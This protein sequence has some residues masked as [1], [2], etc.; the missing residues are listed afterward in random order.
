MIA[1]D[2]RF[3]YEFEADISFT[4][5]LFSTRFHSQPSK[6]VKITQTQ[7]SEGIWSNTWI[8]THK[9]KV[10]TNYGQEDK[11]QNCFIT[12]GNVALGPLVFLV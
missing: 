2:R 9:R 3:E 11:F 12:Y 7:K 10:V 8:D 6:L 1:D 4:T 5:V